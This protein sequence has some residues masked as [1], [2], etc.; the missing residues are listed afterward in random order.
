MAGGE[1]NVWIAAA[2]GEQRWHTL[3]E[4]ASAE[5]NRGERN[6]EGWIVLEG[7][8][9]TRSGNGSYRSRRSAQTRQPARLRENESSRSRRRGGGS[10]GGRRR[11][12]CRGAVLSF[13]C[14]VLVIFSAF[15]AGM[16]AGWYR[17]GREAGPRVELSSI[18]MPDWIEQDLIRKNI[19]SRPAVSL[20]YVN[21]IVVH[22]VANP[23]STA[24]QNRNYF[25]GLADQGQE[26]GT[27]A[28]AHF[29]IGL[30][31]EII[32]CIPIDEIAYAS[33][34]RNYDTIS[35]E[36]CHPDETGKFT[37]ATY[38]SLV[39]LTAWLCDAVKIG[40]ED[41]IR[42]YDV[43]GKACPLYFVDHEEA[44]EAFREDVKNQ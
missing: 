38:Q 6:Q 2:S 10:S 8:G 4:A 21:D 24:K 28:S 17:W 23:G 36:C 43:S 33:N 40:R 14:G 15:L 3:R 37:D 26:G 22:Y 9:E 7:G 41:V 13:L 18:E 16:G 25:D 19:Y 12:G 32:Q 20:Q 42:H 30:E 29:V 11:G 35:I 44:W 31:G 27:S 34:N 1:R 5:E 39:K